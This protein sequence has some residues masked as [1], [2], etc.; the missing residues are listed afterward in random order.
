MS[1]FSQSELIQFLSPIPILDNNSRSVLLIVG[2][3][4]V[5]LLDKPIVDCY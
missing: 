5:A 4:N 1:R 3:G 2:A